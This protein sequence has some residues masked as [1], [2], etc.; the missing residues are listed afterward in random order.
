MRIGGIH[1]LAEILVISV[2]C[3][4]EIGLEL[5]GQYYSMDTGSEAAQKLASISGTA[6]AL[7]FFAYIL[8]M[9]MTSILENYAEI[10]PKAKWAKWIVKRLRIFQLKEEEKSNVQTETDKA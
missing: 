3:G 6:A 2:A 7:L 5:L 1:K 9:E 10:N 8:W 4:L